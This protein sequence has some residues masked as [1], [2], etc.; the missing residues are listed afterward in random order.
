MEE[1]KAEEAQ[2]EASKAEEPKAE[3]AAAEEP[4]AD[5]GSQTTRVLGELA[6]EEVYRTDEE[7]EE[8]WRSGPHCL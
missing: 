3:V 4:R 6:A 7:E 8:W 1:A 5:D 2:A